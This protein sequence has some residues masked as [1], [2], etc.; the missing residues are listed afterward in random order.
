MFTDAHLLR[1]KESVS[2][3]CLDSD[4]KD[5]WSNNVCDKVTNTFNKVII[6]I[7]GGGFTSGS[8]K[9]HQV[10]L[11]DFAKNLGVPIFGIDYRLA[12]KVKY[13]ELNNDCI[14]AYLWIL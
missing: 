4:R 14:S 1:L 11:N 6:W 10:F 5:S 3:A 8:T 2:A 7:H 9:G 12:P 13:P